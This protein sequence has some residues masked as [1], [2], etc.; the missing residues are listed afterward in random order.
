MTGNWRKA[1]GLGA[2]AKSWSWVRFVL[3]VLV[4]IALSI[5]DLQAQPNPDTL[6]TRVYEQ[7]PVEVQAIADAPDGGW[8]VAGAAGFPSDAFAMKI[9][10]QGN[11]VWANSWGDAD[12]FESISGMVAL[13]DGGYV[14][15]GTVYGQPID[16]DQQNYVVRLA[17]AGD[18]LWTRRFGGDDGDWSRDLIEMPNRD[19]L[20]VGDADISGADPG[21][22]GFGIVR[23]TSAGDIV[24][25]R[26]FGTPLTDWASAVVQISEHDYAVC[27]TAGSRWEDGQSRFLMIRVSDEGDSLAAAFFGVRQFA[28]LSAARFVP[29]NQVALV[30]DVSDD[31]QDSD[32]YIVLAGTDGTPIWQR[33]LGGSG[34]DYATAVCREV[35]QTLAVLSTTGSFGAGYSDYWLLGMSLTG[36]SLWSRTYGGSGGSDHGRAIAGSSDAGY[37]CSGFR[38]GPGLDYNGAFIVRTGPDLTS[39]QQRTP[40]PNPLASITCYPNPFNAVA[41]VAFELD[42]PSPYRAQAVDLQGR[43][44]WREQ[45]GMPVRGRQMLRWDATRLA[46]GSYFVQVLTPNGHLQTRITLTK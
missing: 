21:Q 29:P 13:R 11:I 12:L 24:W 17:E 36:D 42:G 38:F 9:D 41:F 26:S 32:S 22:R 8:V 16:Y 10:S 44:V 40:S 6:W 23:I 15:V 33:T 39:A 46:S 4:L 31:G 30:G 25:S 5:H 3:W 35:S 45:T 7:Y 19:L 37:V 18:T 43:V 28:V 27:G 34:N 20:V 1:R 14:L 2:R